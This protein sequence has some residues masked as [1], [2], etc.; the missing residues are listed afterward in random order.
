MSYCT[1]Y[2]TRSN[3][4]GFILKIK[5]KKKMRSTIAPNTITHKH[6]P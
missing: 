2:Q 6:K 1:A 3:K 5:Q 4:K